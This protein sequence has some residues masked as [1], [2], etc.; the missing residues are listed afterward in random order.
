MIEQKCQVSVLGEAAI[1]KESRV[2]GPSWLNGVLLTWYPKVSYSL[3]YHEYLK[4]GPKV[5]CV[6]AVLKQ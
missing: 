3:Q 5:Q 1:G 6:V 2:V 4:L